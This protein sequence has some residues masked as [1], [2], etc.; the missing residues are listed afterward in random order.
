MQGG[1]RLF[2]ELSVWASML[3]ARQCS[4]GSHPS[5]EREGVCDRV[6]Q[7]KTMH[8]AVR[9]MRVQHKYCKSTVGAVMQ[10][11]FMKSDAET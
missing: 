6:G 7:A 11:S 2:L 4:S 8:L 9:A 1:E 5:R 3:L 10:A